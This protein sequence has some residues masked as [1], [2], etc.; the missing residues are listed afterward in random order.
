MSTE[1]TLIIGPQSRLALD[2]NALVRTHRQALGK[3]GLKALPSRVASPFLRRC[4]DPGEPLNDRQV[5]FRR[6]TATP[7]VM[8]AVNLLGP[9]QA[10]LHGREMFPDAERLLFGLGQIAKTARIVILPDS[11]PRFF[12]ASGSDTLEARV[13]ETSWETL[14]DLSWADLVR[15]IRQAL[16]D[17]DLFVLTPDGAVIQSETVLELVFGGAAKVLDP[18]GLLRARLSETGIAVL[19]RMLETGAPN[20]K[21]LEEIYLSFAR[22]PSVIEVQTL[23]GIE[24]ITQT[25]LDQRFADDL[26]A[27]RT[28]PGTKVI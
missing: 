18:L 12:M 8:S 7:T 4:L 19:D 22:H 25:L 16:P 5:A 2:L 11:L 28:L 23:L 21:N 9:P 20:A 27:I 1:L 13:R 10:G 14:Y 17:A 26:D 6:E 24:K 3:A 15:E